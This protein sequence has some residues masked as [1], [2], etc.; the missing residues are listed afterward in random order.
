MHYNV[1]AIFKRFA[2]IGRCE[3]SIYHQWQPRVMG[4]QR[5]CFQIHNLDAWVS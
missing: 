2:E 4:Y 3:C 5:D 1:D